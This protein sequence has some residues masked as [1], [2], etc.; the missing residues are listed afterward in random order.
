[1]IG[2]SAA[3]EE[4]ADRSRDDRHRETKRPKLLSAAQPAEKPEA[5]NKAGRTAVLISGK[6][7]R[8]EIERGV[9][10]DRNRKDKNDPV[11]SHSEI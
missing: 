4:H 11:Q 1:M 10:T 9:G 3:H 8:A 5:T 2:N 6:R 7:I